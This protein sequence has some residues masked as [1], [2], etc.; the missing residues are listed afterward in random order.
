[1]GWVNTR[2][3]RVESDFRV[4]LNRVSYLTTRIDKI[5]VEFS[6]FRVWLE[7]I[8]TYKVYE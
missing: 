8:R 1:M 4:G 5:R 2:P 3:D 7:T 6:G